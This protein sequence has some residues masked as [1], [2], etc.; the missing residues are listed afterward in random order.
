MERSPAAEG[1]TQRIVASAAG[2]SLPRIRLDALSLC[3]SAFALKVVPAV[4]CIEA[5][6]R[7][8]I[9]KQNQS[10]TVWQ[11]AFLTFDELGIPRNWRALGI[12]EEMPE[13]VVEAAVRDCWLVEDALVKAIPADVRTFGA[14][15]GG[16][17][18][19]EN[20]PSVGKDGPEAA[21]I[22]KRLFTAGEAAKAWRKLAGVQ[23]PCS[24]VR[25]V[26]GRAVI[27]G[28]YALSGHV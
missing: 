14:S 13:F 11:G 22:A 5:T 4:A 25:E 23:N 24:T 26:V 19:A 6:G 17:C 16:W 27:V 8:V 2:D 9:N 28:T 7:K 10:I 15:I 3:F 12:P 21:A 20:V 18:W 1:E